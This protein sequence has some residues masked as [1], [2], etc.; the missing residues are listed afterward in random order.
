MSVPG[1]EV[2]G[3]E[4]PFAF[5]LEEDVEAGPCFDLSRGQPHDFFPCSHPP[6]SHEDHVLLISGEKKLENEA[7]LTAK[8]DL[9]SAQ[10]AAISALCAAVLWQFTKYSRESS[11]TRMKTLV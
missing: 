4:Q 5:L 9:I 3:F 1:H 8:V 10:P 2:E 11:N 6:W 7:Q